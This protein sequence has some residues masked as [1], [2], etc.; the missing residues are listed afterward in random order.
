M[1]MSYEWCEQWME[2]A[3]LLSTMSSCPRGQVGAFIVD[4][5]NNPISAGFNGAP[6]GAEGNL[7]SINFC[8]RDDFEVE[9]GTR[10]EVGCHHAEQ[11]ALCNAAKKGIRLENSTMIISTLPCLLCAKLIHHAGISSVVLPIDSK[12]SR[13]GI[14]YLLLHR[15]KIVYI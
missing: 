7:C 1:S 15:I 13:D 11:N 14:N 3:I 12:Y 10:I 5:Y 8:E 4:E 2:Q 9:S 6:R